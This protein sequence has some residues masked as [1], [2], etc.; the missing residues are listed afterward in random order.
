[1]TPIKPGPFPL[2]PGRGAG[3]RAAL[4]AKETL[5]PTLSRGARES[6]KGPGELKL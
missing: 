2:T 4:K 6:G 3:A 5:T 1:M